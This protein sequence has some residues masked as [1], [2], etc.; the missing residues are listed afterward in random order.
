MKPAV[1]AA[2]HEDY[3][4]RV[5]ER[6]ATG[7]L[8]DAAFDQ[9]LPPAARLKS[10][11]HWTPV[12]V[13]RLAAVRLA[14]RGARYVLDA[15][16]GPGKFCVVGASAWPQLTFVG[17]EQRVSLVSAARHLTARL[18]VMN[19]HF[20][21]GD[22]VG[23]SWAPFDGF[24]FFNPFAE[25]AFGTDDVFDA[26]RGV[27]KRRFD[28]EAM[29]IVLRLREARRGSVLVTYHGLGGPIPSSYELTAEEDSGS[30]CLRTWVKARDRE[31]GWV[32][33]DHGS[34]SRVSWCAPPLDAR[35]RARRNANATGR[36]M[37]LERTRTD[38]QPGG[39]SDRAAGLGFQSGLDDLAGER[40]EAVTER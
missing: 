4:D 16:S 19:A 11:L 36:D 3:L 25:N 15:G 37:S 6:L 34:V 13:A 5:R 32:H 31:E 1:R 29:R 18:K 39:G 20:E 35:L 9:L 22:A 21:V 40:F 24:Y 2:M 8:L 14:E 12:R 27:A 23:R 28:S 7:R 26:D 38:L 33:L 17:I 10:T 30:G